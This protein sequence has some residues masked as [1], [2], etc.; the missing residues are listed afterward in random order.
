MFLFFCTA[1]AS[2]DELEALDQN[3]AN[4]RHL[5]P[6]YNN[7][8][9]SSSSAATEFALAQARYGVGSHLERSES[10]DSEVIYIY[11]YTYILYIYIYTSTGVYIYGKKRGNVHIYGKKQRENKTYRLMDIYEGAP[12]GR[13]F[14]PGSIRGPSAS[15]KTGR[16]E[17][18]QQKQMP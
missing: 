11:I 12:A 9:S 13:R 4:Q 14:L 3:G 16:D 1:G 10:R 5:S 18:F 2:S 15:P 6:D 7:E 17:K 8:N